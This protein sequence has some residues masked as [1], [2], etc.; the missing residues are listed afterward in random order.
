MSL[1]QTCEMQLL[2]FQQRQEPADAVRE[3]T[4][5]HLRQQHAVLIEEITDCLRTLRSELYD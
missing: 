2:S 4:L 3:R 1:F 5:R